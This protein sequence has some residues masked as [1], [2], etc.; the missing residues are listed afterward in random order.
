MSWLKRP[1]REG[2]HRKLEGNPPWRIDEIGE[3]PKVVPIRLTV[4]GVPMVHE[5]L[6]ED[7]EYKIVRLKQRMRELENGTAVNWYRELLQQLEGK[8]PPHYEDRP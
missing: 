1:H 6:L 8:D 2:E 4:L 5:S 3:P 7:A